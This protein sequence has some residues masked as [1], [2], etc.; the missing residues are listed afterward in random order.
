[1]IMTQL[2][3]FPDLIFITT[4]FVLGFLKRQIL[5][6]HEATDSDNVFLVIDLYFLCNDVHMCGAYG[7]PAT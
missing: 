2:I 1:M 7:R 6:H 4:L 5:S 3:S